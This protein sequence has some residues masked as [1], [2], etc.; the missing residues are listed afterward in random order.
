MRPPNKPLISL[1][2]SEV[3]FLFFSENQ[4][5]FANGLQNLFVL[6]SSWGEFYERFEA[7][8]S[9]MCLPVQRVGAGTAGVWESAFRRIMSALVLGAELR[10]KRR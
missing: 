8:D 9:G 6:R 10:V 2:K 5:R 1:V 4:A 3:F 7:D